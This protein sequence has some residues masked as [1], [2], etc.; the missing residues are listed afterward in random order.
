MIMTFITNRWFLWAFCSGCVFVEMFLV[1]KW[2]ISFTNKIANAK[3]KAGLN[4]VLGVFTCVALAVLQM[5]ALCDVLKA[6]FYWKFAIAAGFTAT[7]IYLIVEKVLGNAETNALGEAFRS[8]VSHSNLFEGKMSAKGAIAVAN[9]LKEMVNK[10]DKAEASK[11]E[12]AVEKVVSSLDA[13]LEDGKL[14]EKEKLEAEKLV[15]SCNS[16]VLAGNSVYERYQK[17]LNQK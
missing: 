16:S 11:E 10:I 4:M 9:K 7:F 8:V 1:K 6:V 5:W 13:F 2:Y 15:A 12:K 14:T 17:L 3:V